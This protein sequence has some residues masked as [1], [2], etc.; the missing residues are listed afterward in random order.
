[1]ESA[2]QALGGGGCLPVG[3]D[4]G[5]V[6]PPPAAG[7]APPPLPRWWPAAPRLPV[8]KLESL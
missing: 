6:G 2:G 8:V 7:T 4:Q 5:D 3:G 1:M